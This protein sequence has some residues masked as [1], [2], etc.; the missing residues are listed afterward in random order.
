MC[1][2]VVAAI[3]GLAWA[4]WPASP[5]EP[6]PRARQYLEF[7]A[8]ML[9]DGR[10]LV[11]SEAAAVRAGMQEA[12]L[13]T[14]AKVQYL[15]VPGASGDA[16]A[17]TPYLAGL[18]ERRCEV[19]I[20]VGDPQAAAVGRAA[21]EHPDVRFVVVVASAPSPQDAAPPQGTA[22]SPGSPSTINGRVTTIVWSDSATVS[23]RVANV[24]RD[25][26]GRRD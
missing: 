7:T 10:G 8:C 11:G 17:A 18:L 1:G 4:V 5:H 13:A 3:G 12:S 25:A 2:V 16:E 9:T 22:S 14:R 26:V 19:V 21:T 23:T 20:G 6:E 15:P 24:V